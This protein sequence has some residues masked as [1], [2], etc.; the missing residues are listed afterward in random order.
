LRNCCDRNYFIVGYIGGSS[1]CLISKL[2]GGHGR[3]NKAV[4]VAAAATQL[5]RN[6]VIHISQ[7]ARDLRNEIGTDT[8]FLDAVRHPV[9]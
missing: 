2:P 7:L 1:R 6:L 8:V 4:S 5:S 9:V 3:A